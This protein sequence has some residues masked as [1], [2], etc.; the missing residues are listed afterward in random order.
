MAHRI[1]LKR[2]I[3]EIGAD[4]VAEGEIEM[5]TLTVG[6][7]SFRFRE[8]VRYSVTFTNTGGGIVADGTAEALVSTECSRCL[9]EFEM[10]LS[11]AVEGFYVSPDRV[12][13]IPQEQ[14][15][16]LIE[17]D[18]VDIE[19]AVS[20]ALAVDAPFAPLHAEDCAGICPLCGCDRNVEECDCAEEPAASPFD[21]LKGMFAE[22]E[23]GTDEG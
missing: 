14:E 10:T 1:N 16:E 12:E 23:K 8:P 6:D 15:F 3:A 9:S 11:G 19:P 5:E 13:S 4:L 21:V 18:K 7:V 2:I 20:A 22:G 17:D